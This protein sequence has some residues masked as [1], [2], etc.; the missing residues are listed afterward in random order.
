MRYAF[1]ENWEEVR[2]Y[3]RDF[4]AY[5]VKY[6]DVRLYQASGDLGQYIYIFPKQQLV[7]VRMIS[8]QNFQTEEDGFGDF[9]ELVTTIAN[10]L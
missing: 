9:S 4:R 5:E 1:G 2:T 3:L 10:S 6:H 7:F 8:E